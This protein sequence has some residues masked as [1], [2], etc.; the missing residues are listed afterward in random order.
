MRC[1]AL[2]LIGLLAAGVVVACQATPPCTPAGCPDTVTARFEVEPSILVLNGGNMSLCRGE[3]CVTA[4][5]RF[6]EIDSGLPLAV[7]CPVRPPPAVAGPTVDCLN[8]FT[9]PSKGNFVQNVI[10]I[11]YRAPQQATPIEMDIFTIRL[12][13]GAG[14]VVAK[15]N[16]SPIF[17]MP[18]PPAA[19]C[20]PYCTEGT[21]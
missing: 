13:N 19:S 15:R 8:E 3:V 21:L 18:N 16:G 2:A 14:D 12:T 9:E 7:N 11:L 20:N 17:A 5:I 4:R 6:D 1:R 10:S